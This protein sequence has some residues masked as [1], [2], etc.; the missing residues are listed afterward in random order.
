MGTQSLDAGS[1]QSSLTAYPLS[2][3][4]EEQRPGLSEVKHGEL[5]GPGTTLGQTYHVLV[6]GW[7]ASGTTEGTH[8]SKDTLN[9]I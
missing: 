2:A 6:Q 5:L 8:L 9:V 3:S 4:P 1:K 7:A